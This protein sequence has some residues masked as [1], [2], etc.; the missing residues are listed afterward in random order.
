VPS[1]L[2]A[3]EFAFIKERY[4]E[5]SVIME[6]GSGG[7]TLAAT[8]MAQKLVLTIEPNSGTA[9]KLIDQV[10]EGKPAS[11]HFVH[12]NEEIWKL[13]NDRHPDVILVQGTERALLRLKFQVQHPEPEGR[14]MLQWTDEASTS[15]ARNVA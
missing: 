11:R 13:F 6:Y 7:T 14:R 9:K 1:G 2:S 3:A 4:A 8:K 15:A 5:A 12:P 10:R